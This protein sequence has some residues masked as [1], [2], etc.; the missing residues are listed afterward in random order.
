MT[1]LK[2]VK[3]DKLGLFCSSMTACK[4]ML[5]QLI[6]SSSYTLQNFNIA[7]SIRE[8]YTSRLPV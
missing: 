1:K 3:F 6:L 8:A 7:V 5:C 2:I 4:H